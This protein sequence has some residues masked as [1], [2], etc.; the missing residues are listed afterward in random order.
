MLYASDPPCSPP[1]CIPCDFLG[2]F[3]FF[4]SFNTWNDFWPSWD[5]CSTIFQL[6]VDGNIAPAHHTEVTCCCPGILS[7]EALVHHLCR[8]T[9]SFLCSECHWTGCRDLHISHCPH[10]DANIMAAHPVIHRAS[11]CNHNWQ[12]NR[13]CCEI[14]CH[15]AWSLGHE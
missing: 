13:K 14:R 4:S 10:I 12:Q 2:F 5:S 9:V 8:R 15:T 1:C 7:Q 11:E 3:F 6:L